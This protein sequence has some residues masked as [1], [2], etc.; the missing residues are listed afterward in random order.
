VAKIKIF[1]DADVIISALLS[2]TG[3]SYEVL[4]NKKVDKF[5]SLQVQKEVRGVSKRLN[6]KNKIPSSLK[7]LKLGLTKKSLLEKYQ[8]Y[9]YDADGSHVVAGAI[10]SK[11]GFLLTHN[12]RH[13]KV[14]RIKS[15]F[16]VL[17]TTPGSFLQYLRSVDKI[18]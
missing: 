5:A 2:K 6:L 14:D 18:S 15:S 7:V 8:D 1:L 16:D 11:S 17:V 10:I 9:V 13:F 12:I 3:A 4:K